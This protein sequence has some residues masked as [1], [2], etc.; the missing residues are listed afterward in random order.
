MAR[1]RADRDGFVDSHY[2]CEGDEFE[3]DG[4]VPSWATPLDAAPMT[5]SAPAKK[6][7]RRTKAKTK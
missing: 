2:V 6:P 7:V 4:P 1:Y 3:Y 5:E